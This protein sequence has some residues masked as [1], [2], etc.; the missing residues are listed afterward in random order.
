MKVIQVTGARE[1]NRKLRQIEQNALSVGRLELRQVAKR[2]AARAKQLAPVET[3]ELRDSIQV[4]TV[5][6]DDIEVIAASYYAPWVEYGTE[7]MAPRP[8]MR[9]AI[10]DVGRS[11]VDGVARR[12]G[13][14]I[15][16]D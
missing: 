4:H 3:G 9:P 16:F 10:D 15:D 14:T 7:K 11:A 12:I 5:D 13:T 6:E 2:I 1:L 8:F